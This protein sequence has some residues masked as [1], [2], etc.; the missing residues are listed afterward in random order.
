[1]PSDHRGRQVG[2]PQTSH[3]GHAP[4]PANG[5]YPEIGINVRRM[6][7]N[8]P[9]GSSVLPVSDYSNL[10]QPSRQDR[11]EMARQDMESNQ[12]VEGAQKLL[13][14]AG[15]EGVTRE[16]HEGSRPLFRSIDT[17]GPY[18]AA[19]VYDPT[20]GLTFEGGTPTWTKWGA[21]R[22]ARKM[23]ESI[24]VQNMGFAEPTAQD[25]EEMKN[26]KNEPITYDD[27]RR[28]LTRG[29]GD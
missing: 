22:S 17:A 2:N 12:R 15:P 16:Q 11:A 18:Y 7:M 4:R 5:M 9:V 20:R 28:K 19:T 27:P 10:P 13:G 6:K 21:R 1:M 24:R 26:R 14:W 25:I 3:G 23:A 29:I 8:T